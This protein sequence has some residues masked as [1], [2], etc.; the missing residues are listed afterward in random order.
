MPRTKSLST[1]AATLRDT[2]GDR[3]IPDI[4]RKI[5]ACVACRKLKIKCVITDAEEPCARCKQRGLSCTVNRSLQMLLEGD[6]EWKERI[7]WRIDE[8]ET[9]LGTRKGGDLDGRRTC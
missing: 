6:A 3:K 5:T 2:F 1:A 7:E 4:S 8:I 9:R